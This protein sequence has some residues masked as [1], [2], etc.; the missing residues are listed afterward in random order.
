MSV[1][2]KS[3][4][5]I[6]L[7]IYSITAH[8]YFGDLDLVNA[9]AGFSVLETVAQILHPN[10]FISDYPG[11]SGF[12]NK[13]L[14]VNLYIPLMNIT[15]LS[16][17]K[18]Q[19]LMIGFEVI[20]ISLSSI[21]LLHTLI[22]NSEINKE[23]QFI[24]FFGIVAVITLSSFTGKNLAGFS[25]SYYHGIFYGFADAA[26]LLA[27][28]FILQR[29]WVLAAICLCLGF[30][31]HP[32]KAL[33]AGLFIAGVVSVDW[34]RSISTKSVLCGIFSI[35]AVTAWVYFVYDIGNPKSNEVLLTKD[36]AAYTRIF[37]VHWYPV[38]AEYFGRF[39]ILRT[40][41][42]I[43]IIGMMCLAIVQVNFKNQ[44]SSRIFAGLV[45]LVIS[46]LAGLWIS[47]D[48]T[49]IN[50]IK[51]C[52]IRASTLISLLA[53]FF[54][55]L[56]VSF[57]WQKK[58]WHWVAFYLIFVAVGFVN[59]VPLSA[60]LFV[61]GSCFWFWERRSIHWPIATL[62]IFTFLI[63]LIF[64]LLNLEERYP[65]DTSLN[66][67]LVQF[68]GFILY[69]F[70]ITVF[71]FLLVNAN[72]WSAWL[73]RSLSAESARR[74]CLLS[75]FTICALIWSERKWLGSAYL[76]R[77]GD[78]KE[79]QI[80]AKNNTDPTSLFMVDPCISYGWRDFSHRSSIGTPRE[81]YMTGWLYVTDKDRFSLGIEIGD[82]LGLNLRPH[83]SER[84]EPQ[85][86][87][88]AEVCKM[89]EEL[90]YDPKME[91]V[92][93]IAQ[94]YNVDYFVFERQKLSSLPDWQAIHPRFE[95]D[96]FWVI[97]RE[98]IIK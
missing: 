52:F 62:A 7:I 11:G 90:Y 4:P 86:I 77:A 14:L 57:Y 30:A 31:I 68:I 6:L 97:S 87:R 12:T 18:I 19:Y 45:V 29:Y 89:A 50:L 27:I 40:A 28:A 58:A 20:I 94:R 33:M 23:I 72:I 73:H 22:R 83:L 64:A 75:L 21:Y 5:I 74:L 16:A 25:F 98:Q 54:I 82:T 8:T 78:F 13:S 81:W 66:Q 35:T 1:T 92:D 70:L 49:S 39:Y 55:L 36:F 96:H 71:Y 59:I 60:H 47:Y 24:I 84:G 93:R 37:Q 34:R 80:W 42:V 2:H 17:Q 48:L 41:P 63:M 15:N 10:N 88:S 67:L 26:R 65:F 38:Y 61:I 56:A 44:L 43:A 91:P 85:K 95:N 53:P 32:I 9:I 69:A 3:V 46:T 51:I 76:S 79:V